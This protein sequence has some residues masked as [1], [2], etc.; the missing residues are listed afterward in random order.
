MRHSALIASI[1]IVIVT[2]LPGCAGHKEASY[3]SPSPA[4]G[5]RVQNTYRQ[6]IELATI[7]L[8]G[9]A[10]L[11]VL[12]FDHPNSATLRLLIKIPEG[13]SFEFE[14]VEVNSVSLTGSPVLSAEIV[15]IQGNIIT[16]GIGAFVYFKG[17]ARLE[18]ATYKYK[19]AFGGEQ[20]VHRYF[21]TDIK[22]T[23]ALPDRFQIKLPGIRMKRGRVVLPPLLFERKLGSAY[24][25]SPP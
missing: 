13:E 23:S 9:D 22:F 3:F 4:D 20:A 5:M 1:A 24:L 25:G 10:A 16:A 11:E 6:L 12:V 17:N 8:G 15:N 2:L 21:E 19:K 18:G 14:N 7:P